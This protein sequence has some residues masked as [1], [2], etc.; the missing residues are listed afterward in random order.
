MSTWTVHAKRW[1]HGWELCIDGVG[2][3]Q[4]R[5]LRDAPATVADYIRLDT[6]TAP[7]LSEIEIVPE[8]GGGLAEEA[9][10][11]RRAVADADRAQREAASQSRETAR[12]LKGAG[13]T[14]QDIAAVL[15]LSPQR[16][17]QLL[18]DRRSARLASGT[19]KR[20]HA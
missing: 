5:N 6:G 11:A 10:A 15:R 12:K 2:I 20:I 17:S 16:V 3:T 19:R 14:G 13:L 1:K 4:S 18:A 7:D 8:I 9:R